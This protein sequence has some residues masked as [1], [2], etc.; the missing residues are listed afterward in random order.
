ML[1]EIVKLP[2][3]GIMGVLGGLYF[4][5]L[6]MTLWRAQVVGIDNIER[7]YRLD[8]RASRRDVGWGY[9]RMVL[10]GSTKDRLLQ[11]LFWLTRLALAL[12]VLAM[13][14]TLM[15]VGSPYRMSLR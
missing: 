14:V 8:P 7:G 11:A 12:C 6:S 2:L 10:F 5:V 3:N 1:A 9:A 15:I 13:F 4:T